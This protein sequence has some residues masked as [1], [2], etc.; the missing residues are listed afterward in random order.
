[1]NILPNPYKTEKLSGSFSI[2]ENSKIFCDSA[3]LTQAERL[4]DLVYES[5]G[6][7]LQFTD[8][9]EEAQ[10]IFANSDK[11]DPEGYILMISQGVVTVNASTV[12][13][14]FYAVET[15]R[16]V[17][18]LDTKQEEI[19]CA[20]C[21][22]E[23]KPRF[24]HR[25][26]MVDI[27]RHFYGV[28]TLKQIVELMSQVKLNKLHL[29]LTDDQGFRV[30]IDKYPLLTEIGSVRQGSEVV[31]DGKRYVDDEPHGGFLTKNDIAELVSYAAERNIE[32]IPEVDLPGHFVAA[33]AAYPEY[34]CTHQVSEVRKS[35]GISKDILCA[36]NDESYEFVKNIL[37]EIAEMF[38]SEYIHLGGDEVPKD[39]WCNCKLCRE[40]M[41][42]LKL[43]SYDEL[44]AHMVEVF[45]K[46]LEAKGKKVICWND[47]VKQ[48]TD[49]DI[50]SQV[51][52]PFKRKKAIKQ[53]KRGRK[54]ILSPCFRLYFD[55]PY[56]LTPLRK[57]LKFNPYRGV[58]KHARK[59]VLGVEGTLWTEYV[60]CPDRLF[61]QLLPR[62]DALS[63]V[64]WGSRK[65]GFFKRVTRR[66]ELY[67]K[68]GLTYNKR[69]RKPV[70][71]ATT[72][73]KF[74]RRDS[75]VEFSKNK[76]YEN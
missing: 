5:C 3:F 11:T 21:Y 40:R 71:R 58:A 9:I 27:C 25:G 22:I 49:L 2:A 68:L 75:D 43:N 42:E 54:V 24:Y 69:L 30:Q 10:I 4:A 32:I 59:N 38:P 63:E 48:A 52:T 44:Q 8:V 26:L 36:G 72:V 67:D 28:D 16:Q 60:S 19:T 47:G 37:D 70:G 23:D 46:H 39:R 33:L 53:T 34:S 14:C 18:N 12:E 20:N 73:R 35:W 61:F 57:T 62:L 1:M 64:A 15:L 50:V 45:R 76:Q 74:F 51:W 55:Y 7:F 31:K 41:A 6:K 66:L 29:H 56:A 13:G 65:K 17:F